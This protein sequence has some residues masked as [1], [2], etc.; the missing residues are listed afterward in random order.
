LRKITTAS[1]A[2]GGSIP[3][4]KQF[5]HQPRNW[6]NYLCRLAAVHA[7]PGGFWKNPE[8]AHQTKTQIFSS[9]N[10]NQNTFAYESKIKHA[11]RTPLTWFPRL[12]LKIEAFP[13]IPDELPLTLPQ[14]STLVPL[15]NSRFSFVNTL[16]TIHKLSDSRMLSL[17]P[18]IL[19]FNDTLMV[20][21][22]IKQK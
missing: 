4:A 11:V 18:S 9:S 1:T 12:D 10:M 22:Q 14:T 6:R 3:A 13:W 19:P 16:L 2:P 7:P 8:N 17:S 21:N 20:V 15:Q 5:I